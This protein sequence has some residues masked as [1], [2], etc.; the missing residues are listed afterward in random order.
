MWVR[1][2]CPASRPRSRLSGALPL[3]GRNRSKALNQRAAERLSCIAL[4]PSQIGSRFGARRIDAGSS[5]WCS[6]WNRASAGALTVAMH[7]V[8]ALAVSAACLV[9]ALAAGDGSPNRW[10]PSRRDDWAGCNN[11]CPALQRHALLGERDPAWPQELTLAFG[12]K[13]AIGGSFARQIG[14]P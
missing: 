14:F 5:A 13:P 9:A 4:T 2:G 1:G 10:S 6:V 3:S 11:D 8:F 12:Y 7:D